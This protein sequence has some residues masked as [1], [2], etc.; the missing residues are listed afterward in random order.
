[1]IEIKQLIR[2]NILALKPYSSSRELHSGREGILLDANENPYGMLNRYPDPYQRALKNKLAI[3]KGVAQENIFFGNGSDEVIDLAFRIFCNPTVDKALTFSPTYGMYS[4]SAAINNIELISLP[5]GN[6]FQINMD[7]LST[8]FN[9]TRIKLIFICSPNNP[10]GN[11]INNSDIMFIINKFKGVVII[12]EAYIDFANTDSFINLLHSHNN[13]IVMQTFSKAWGLAS[14][15][16]GMA[17][18]NKEII[19]VYNRVKPPYNVSEINQQAAIDVL[20]NLENYRE[21]LAL[22]N[23][24]KER[25]KSKLKTIN[26]V[27][28]I[29]PSDANFLLIEV[30]DANRLYKYLVTQRIIIRNRDTQIANCLRISIGTA[31]ENEKLINALRIYI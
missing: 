13:L 29:Y 25:L 7:K 8:Y 30:T 31:Y 14:A 10:T 5:L 26:C 17:Y 19:S 24:E 4:V 22:I 2:P 18:S 21:K 6:D 1:M 20:E 12:D 16:L 3:F 23:K 11:L 28:K 27:K 9:D 15:R